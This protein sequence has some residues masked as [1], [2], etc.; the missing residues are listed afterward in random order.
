MLRHDGLRLGRVSFK[1]GVPH[2][3]GANPRDDGEKRDQD[4]EVS[5]ANSRGGRSLTEEQSHEGAF[6]SRSGI[7]GAGGSADSRARRLRLR[8]LLNSGIWGLVAPARSQPSGG[9]RASAQ[10]V[11]QTLRTTSGRLGSNGSPAG[12]SIVAGSPPRAYLPA[13]D[14]QRAQ[15]LSPRREWS[16]RSLGA[17]GEACWSTWT[18]AEPTVGEPAAAGAC[19][20]NA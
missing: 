4:H 20:S 3:E 16:T 19:N 2:P 15:Q 9:P 18:T 1:K 7:G 10:A 6:G 5:A 12:V 14:V 13:D 11:V 17:S 8:K